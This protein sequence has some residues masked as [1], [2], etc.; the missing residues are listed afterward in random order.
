MTNLGMVLA[1]TK[2]CGGNEIDMIIPTFT[3]AIMNLVMIFIP[4]ILI[5]YGMLDLAKAVMANDDKV[6]KEA[7]TK[8]IHRIIYAVVIFFVVAIVKLVFG[9]LASA[10]EQSDVNSVDK[11]SIT[12]CINC[13]ISGNC[14]K[15][16]TGTGTTRK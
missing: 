14:G 4:I 8:L 5:A 6:M 13:F 1:T 3:S 15:A 11:S 10:S 7:Q 16:E 2:V 12:S 9:M